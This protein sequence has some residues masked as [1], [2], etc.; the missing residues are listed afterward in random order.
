MNE[1][2]RHPMQARR[3]LNRAFFNGSLLVAS[4]AGAFTGSW[5][6]FGLTLGILVVAN[7]YT[8][9]IRPFRRKR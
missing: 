2:R 6:V 1:K 5:L 7:I 9:E 8:G 3:K 4:A